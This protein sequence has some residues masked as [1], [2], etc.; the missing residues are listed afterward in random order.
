MRV[1][2]GA[3]DLDFVDVVV[4]VGVADEVV[5]G[6]KV[7]AETLKDIVHAPPVHTFA[8]SCWMR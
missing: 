1:G 4:C 7:C 3:A 2:V 8:H 5:V 6:V